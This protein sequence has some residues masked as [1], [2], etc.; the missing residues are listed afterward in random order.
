[1]SQAVTVIPS[2]DIERKARPLQ[3]FYAHEGAEEL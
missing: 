2:V 1:M 3:A